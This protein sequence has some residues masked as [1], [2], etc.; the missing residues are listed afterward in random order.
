MSTRT[1][2]EK[3]LALLLARSGLQLTAEQVRAMLP[4]VPAIQ[5]MI[6]RINA[7]LPREAEPAAMFDVE[8][9]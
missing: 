1:M 7:P 8:Q 4:G 3:E 5:A 2:D 6:D 9:R